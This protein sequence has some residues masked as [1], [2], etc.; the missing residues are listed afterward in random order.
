M[1]FTSPAT[2]DKVV[3]YYA[4][5]ARDADYGGIAV[6]NAGRT[7]TFTATKGDGEKVTI[8]A[9]PTPKGSTGHIRVEHGR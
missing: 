4:A 2:P 8:T 9:T 7:A 5:A 1:R 6:S 3:A